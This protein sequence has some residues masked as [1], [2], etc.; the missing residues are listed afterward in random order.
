MDKKKS[1]QGSALM[2]RVFVKLKE[3][4]ITHKD[5]MLKIER[6]DE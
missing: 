5:L 2:P 3:M 1:S 4:V 6:H